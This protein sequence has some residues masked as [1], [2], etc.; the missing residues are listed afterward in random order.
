MGSGKLILQGNGYA[1]ISPGGSNKL[2]RLSPWKIQPKGAP[3]IQNGNK[4]TKT[5]GGR[6]SNMDH[7]SSKD[8]QETPTL[9]TKHYNLPTWGHIKTLKN[10]VSQQGMPPS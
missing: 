6:N 10:L 2:T 1:S 5:S 8:L 3:N 7:V 4:T 9:A